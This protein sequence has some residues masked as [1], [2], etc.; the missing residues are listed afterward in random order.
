MHAIGFGPRFTVNR[1]VRRST[2]FD[3]S[4]GALPPG[5][6]LSRAS[7]ATCYDAGGAIVSHAANVGRFDRHPVTGALRGLLIEP[8]ATNAL[9]RSTD[10]SDGYWS[11]ST[12]TVS[13]GVLIETAANGAH[14]VRQTTG[15]VSYSAGQPVTASVIAGERS[16]SAKRY[17]V[18]SLGTTPVF[19]ATTFAIFDLASGGVTAFGNGT[20]ATFP[21]GGGAWLC[22]FSATPVAAA[23]AQQIV[24]RVNASATA[25]A[26]Y[27]GDGASGLN[28]TH[29]QI[30]AGT[31][32]TSRIVTGASAA[33]RAPDVLLLDWRS[34]G[35]A[36]GTV[37]V[38]YGFDDGSTQ[39]STLSV[40]GGTATVPVTLA[41]RWIRRIHKI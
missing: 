22:V 7:A 20:A 30:E 5:A 35:V 33:T 24:L 6:S 12:V 36:D 21:A 15:D 8:A 10:W 40:S 16:G 37:G 31:A 3:F 14:S 19:S 11:K 38:R 29:L 41:R 23:S 17:L 4:G 18:L 2:V 26:G 9:A 25:I 34:R 39:D 32:A 27:V 13:A 28:V 1:G